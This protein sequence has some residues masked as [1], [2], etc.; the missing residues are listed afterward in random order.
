MICFHL[1]LS[2]SPVVDTWRPVPLELEVHSFMGSVTHPLYFQHRWIFY[3]Y[4]FPALQGCFGI[5]LVYRVN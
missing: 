3:K 4:D 2:V 5:Q 1:P